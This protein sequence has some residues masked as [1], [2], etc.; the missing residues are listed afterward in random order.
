MLGLNR[1]EIKDI[2]PV[3]TKNYRLGASTG[4]H[5]TR[6]ILILQLNGERGIAILCGMENISLGF[7]RLE[8]RYIRCRL[9]SLL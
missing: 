2:I 1:D 7:I 6:E 4:L 5:Q 8:S 3:L 9:L